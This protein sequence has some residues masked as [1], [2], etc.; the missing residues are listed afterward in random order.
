MENTEYKKSWRLENI[1]KVRKQALAYVNRERDKD[2]E[3]FLKRMREN[4][5]RYRLNHLEECRIKEK[6][7]SRI[8]RNKDKD[9]YNLE[10][11]EYR[12]KNP[13]KFKQYSVKRKD[14]SKVYSRKRTIEKYGIT[15]E[16]YN[17]ML[18]KQEGKC[19]LCEEPIKSQINIDH[20]HKTGV[21][22]GLLCSYCNTTLGYVE[23]NI[24][25]RPDIF[26]RI[27]KYL[28]I[29]SNQL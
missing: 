12:R 6:E 11:R 1:E 29:Q 9:A 5:K 8:R 13:E 27:T 10:Q 3:G 20:C 14:W 17:Q 19:A 28:K 26:D 23:K 22:R 18:L 25:I 4:A 16:Q 2:R 21:V 24:A 7:K 15:E